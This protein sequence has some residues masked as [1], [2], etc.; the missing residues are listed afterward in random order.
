[1]TWSRRETLSLGS[2]CHPRHPTASLCVPPSHQ[3]CWSHLL[4]TYNL[5]LLTGV[6]G[7]VLI[8]QGWGHL[9][10]HL[11]HMDCDRWVGR[12]R[13]EQ[14]KGSFRRPPQGCPGAEGA[15]RSLSPKGRAGPLGG[16]RPVGVDFSSGWERAFLQAAPLRAGAGW[17]SGVSAHS[18]G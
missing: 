5:S 9:E 12:W 10:P 18:W 3:L 6:P 11:N 1:M 8:D 4:S 2:A 15:T 17:L 13:E 14:E 16:V 7:Q